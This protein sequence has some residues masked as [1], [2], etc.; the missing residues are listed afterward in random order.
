MLAVEP[1]DLLGD[2]I[3]ETADIVKQECKDNNKRSAEVGRNEAIGVLGV[4]TF[5]LAKYAIVQADL[6]VVERT[7]RKVLSAPAFLGDLSLARTRPSK[8]T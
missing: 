4:V 6:N 3:D 7:G 2:V 1:V 5:E 8:L